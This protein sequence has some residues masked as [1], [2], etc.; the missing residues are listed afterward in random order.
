MFPCFVRKATRKSGNVTFC[1]QT[2]PGCAYLN[3]SDASYPASF[4]NP[5]IGPWILGPSFPFTDGARITGPLQYSTN[6]SMP[7]TKTM[8]PFSDCEDGGGRARLIISTD[9]HSYSNLS[10]V[11]INSRVWLSERTLLFP[12]CKSL[13][14]FAFST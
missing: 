1:H 12:S 9:P 8:V 13:V 6:P 10:L 5:K 4:N 11:S 14:M 2:R 7:H 3:T